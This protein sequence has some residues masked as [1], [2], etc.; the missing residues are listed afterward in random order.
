MTFGRENLKWLGGYVSGEQPRRAKA[1]LNT[2]EN[3]FPPC[4][5]VLRVLAG[6]DGEMLRQYPDLT[7]QAFRAEAARLHGLIPDNIIA[8]KGGDELL[9]LALT[10]F[11]PTG[12][13]LG[14]AEP[15]YSLY[16]VLAAVHDK[17]DMCAL[18][19]IVRTL[20]QFRGYGRLCRYSFFLQRLTRSNRRR[21]PV[22]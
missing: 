13:P 5:A 9:R 7:A 21:L 14:L 19:A 4:D 22:P 15:S 11:L 17:S 18:Y 12:S 16:P 2:N 10:T 6:I 3:P 1:K 8:T 20:L